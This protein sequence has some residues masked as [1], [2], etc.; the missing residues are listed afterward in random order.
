MYVNISLTQTCGMR[1]QYFIYNDTVPWEHLHITS[2][3]CREAISQAVS[4][5]NM[6]LFKNI[7]EFFVV[8]LHDIRIVLVGQQS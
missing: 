8:G 5:H 2:P 4:S 7:D 1:L 3:L 6:V